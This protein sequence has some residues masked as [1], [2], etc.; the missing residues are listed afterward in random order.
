MPGEFDHV[1]L[2]VAP[3]AVFFAYLICALLINLVLPLATPAPLATRMVGALCLAGGL[4]LGLYAVSRM[5]RAH[6][7]VDP[8]RPSTALVTDGPF[9]LTRNPVY[10]GFSLIF[11]GTTLI[12]GTLWGLLLMP[13]LI[14][15]MN[16]IIIRAEESY[17]RNR[18]AL[19]Y[20]EYSARVRRWL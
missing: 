1:R 9:R 5:R 3:P 19:R 12:V 11:L 14:L 15:T 10:L 6:T 2:P 13:F 18:F 20:E 16:S 7:P 8:G 17:L 4:L